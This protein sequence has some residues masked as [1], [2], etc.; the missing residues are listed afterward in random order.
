M[1]VLRPQESSNGG[2]NTPKF[3]QSPGHSDEERKPSK[4]IT[5]KKNFNL[6]FAN[7]DGDSER[8]EGGAEV[9]GVSSISNFQITNGRSE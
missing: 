6:S 8:E 4:V 2:S 7:S 1:N 9:Q 5:F 3:L